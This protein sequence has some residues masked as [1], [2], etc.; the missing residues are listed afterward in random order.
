MGPKGVR[1]RANPRRGSGSS[2]VP[3]QSLSM[4]L[5]R[6]QIREGMDSIPIEA[7]LGKT[8][9]N[10]LTAKQK[11]FAK[12]VAMGKPKAEAY[13]RSYKA[14]A[15]K[16]TLAAEPYRLASDPRVAREIDAYALA[17]EAEKHRTPAALRSLVIHQLTKH[18]IDDDIPPAQ[19]IKALQLLGQITEVAAFTERKEVRTVTSSE[20]VR[21][22]IMAE[23]RGMLSASAT[24]IETIDAQAGDLLAELTEART[25]GE[26]PP[27]IAGDGTDAPTHTIPPEQFISE[28][29]PPLLKNEAN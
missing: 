24:D 4:K 8:V 2:S 10:G 19:R 13:R 12:Q 27:D 26:A 16:R 20:D 18:A 22:N 6:K 14:D 9:S 5:S 28:S 25:H 15:S 29:D 11:E 7:I 21:Q 17:I 3:L 23:L 1:A